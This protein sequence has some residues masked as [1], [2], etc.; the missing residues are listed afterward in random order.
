VRGNAAYVDHLQAQGAAIDT[1]IQQTHAQDTL[2]LRS[3]PRVLLILP[4]PAY[5]PRTGGAV[6][7]FY[8][9]KALHGKVDLVVASLL[10]D[11]ANWRVKDDLANYAQLALVVDTG[12]RPP[13]DP[14]QPNSI[15]RYRSPGFETVLKQLSPV[16]FD[17]VV[18]DFM[19]MAQYRDYFPQAFHVLSEHNIESQIVRRSGTVAKDQADQDQGDQQAA[20]AILQEADH[21]AAFEDRMWPQYPLRFVVSEQD[22]QMLID[23]CPIGETVVVNNGANTREIQL[24]P[25]D[26]HVELFA[27]CRWRSLFRLADF[28]PCVAAESQGGVLD[29]G[30]GSGAGSAAFGRTRSAHQADR[31]SRCNGRCG[32]TMLSLRRAVADWQWHPD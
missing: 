29:C 17:I 6:R 25:D 30:G 5:P 32:G 16:N 14:D 24:L 10:Y 9:M 22:R 26:W 4:G 3:R 15:H 7:S 21:L 20:L 23:R 28:A 19:F 31:Q 12:E 1:Y 11:K 13:R 8:E 2:G 18:S 27:Q